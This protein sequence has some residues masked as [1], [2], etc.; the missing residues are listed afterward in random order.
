M[1]TVGTKSVAGNDRLI[2]VSAYL[3]AKH[4]IKCIVKCII[5][6]FVANLFTV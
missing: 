1:D 6:T 3:E 2:D 4:F 5:K